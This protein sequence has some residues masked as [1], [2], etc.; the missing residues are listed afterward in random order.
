M[1]LQ[2]GR[3][4]C[5][6]EPIPSWEALRGARVVRG[7]VRLCQGEDWGGKVCRGVCSQPRSLIGGDKWRVWRED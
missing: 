2:G 1:R 6:R 7:R 5:A 4:P 3:F